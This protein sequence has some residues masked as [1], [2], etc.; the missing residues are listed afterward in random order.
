MPGALIGIFLRGL[1]S[2]IKVDYFQ[3]SNVREEN[4]CDRNIKV[5]EENKCGRTKLEWK[6][7]I[8]ET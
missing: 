8:Y 6:T 7:N 3:D 5:K 1:A 2:D 4:T